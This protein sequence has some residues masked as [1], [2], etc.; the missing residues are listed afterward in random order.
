VNRTPSRDAQRSNRRMSMASSSPVPA[1]P[2][3]SSPARRGYLASRTPNRARGDVR[4]QMPN[5]RTP[6]QNASDMGVGGPP[7][8][9]DESEMNGARFTSEMDHDQHVHQVWGTTIDLNR[10][11]QAFEKFFREYHDPSGVSD[12]P[13][14]LSLLHGSEGDVCECVCVR[15]R[16]CVMYIPSMY[17]CRDHQQQRRLSLHQ[18][19]HQKSLRVV[20]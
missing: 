11:R 20:A 9:G 18:P 7:P 8:G 19:Q 2:R 10:S 6:R 1:T 12:Q 4:G 3:D 17:L 15:E 14:Y 13:Y 5:Y 16:V